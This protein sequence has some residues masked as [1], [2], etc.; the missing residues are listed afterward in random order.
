[1]K[2]KQSKS[3]QMEHLRK[4]WKAPK[5]EKLKGLTIQSNPAGSFGTSDGVF[6]S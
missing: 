2:T 1:M 3:A 6:Y 4:T 5:M